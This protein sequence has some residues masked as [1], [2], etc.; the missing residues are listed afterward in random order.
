MS[1]SNDTN[2]DNLTSWLI[3]IA[4]NTA[5]TR[6]SVEGRGGFGS[7]KSGADDES[8]KGRAERAL[9]ALGK[10]LESVLSRG[11]NTPGEKPIDVSMGAAMSTLSSGVSSLLGTSR[12]L[13]NHGF[14]GTTEQ[15]ERRTRGPSGIGQERLF[16]TG[17][18]GAIGYRVGG[19]I[20]TLAGGMIGNLFAGGGMWGAALLGALETAGDAPRRDVTPYN[21]NM[22]EAGGTYF[23]M[24]E[25]VIRATA[26]TGAEDDP[27]KQCADFLL[28]I[29]SLLG[30][31]VG[32]TSGGTVAPAP[33]AATGN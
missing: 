8:S 20:G 1:A 6:D 4:E 28:Q 3:K 26:G 16:G 22:V 9:E 29:I 21:P 32:I 33:V 7:G 10:R 12:G 15:A 2:F 24:R 30:Q 25:G 31:L 23:K 19:P 13:A 5:R 17:V 11:G 18:G 27:H 14:F